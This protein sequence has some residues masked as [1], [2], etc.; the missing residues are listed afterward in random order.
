[1]EGLSEELL[2]CSG[3]AYGPPLRLQYKSR[4]RSFP[5]GTWENR[6]GGLACRRKAASG[7]P[8]GVDS[9]PINWAVT[10][11]SEFL[12]QVVCEF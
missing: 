8:A 10:H 7:E 12:K 9:R 1:M 2:K 4:S 5:S 3:G 6:E 11:C